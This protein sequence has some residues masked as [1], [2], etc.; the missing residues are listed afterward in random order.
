MDNYSNF[1][2]NIIV[3]YTYY[4]LCRVAYAKGYQSG[5]P[6]KRSQGRFGTIGI[7]ALLVTSI[8]TG[9]NTLL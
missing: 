6:A 7:L 1:R 5:D 3:I 2:N 8:L 9:V 4:L